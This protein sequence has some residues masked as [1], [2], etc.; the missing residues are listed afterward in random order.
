MITVSNAGPLIACAKV[1]R[2]DLLHNLFDQV[3]VPQAVYAEVV[4]R[5]AGRAGADE[6][7]GAR[8]RW[9]RVERVKNL[10]LSRSLHI[11]LGMGESEAIALSIELGADVLLLDDRKARAMARYL[12]LPVVGTVG[13]LLRANRT[14]LLPD[15]E[16]ALD[17]LRSHGFR[18]SDELYRYALGDR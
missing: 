4:I 1:G 18:I 12:G 13:V 11:Q 6:T 10:A 16:S 2:F 7:Q 14:G 9:I 15:L 17:E 8:Q 3:T 5:G